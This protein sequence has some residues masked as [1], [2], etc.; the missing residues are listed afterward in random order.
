MYRIDSGVKYAQTFTHILKLSCDSISDGN[1]QF[2]RAWQMART[3][4][5][6]GPSHFVKWNGDEHNV[7][8]QKF[9]LHLLWGLF[10]WDLFG[11]SFGWPWARWRCKDSNVAVTPAAAQAVL[12]T[13]DLF[14]GDINEIPALLTTGTIFNGVCS[15]TQTNTQWD[16]IWT[17]LDF[18]VLIHSAILVCFQVITYTVEQ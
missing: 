9:M 2:L 17:T 10:T 6:K 7:I 18:L 15:F 5:T 1:I 11:D 4:T 13:E 14:A 8:W 16:F 12:C 3:C